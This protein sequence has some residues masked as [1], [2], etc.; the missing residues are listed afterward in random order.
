MF[1]M[2]KAAFILL[3]SKVHQ[4]L[5]THVTPLTA[6]MAKLSSVSQVDTLLHLA[7]TIRWLA[8][9]SYYFW[10]FTTAIIPH[11]RQVLLGTLPLH[12]M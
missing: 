9:G 1:R 3:H 11:T 4:V 12:L 2:D 10:C 6:K 8:G 7:S 5:T